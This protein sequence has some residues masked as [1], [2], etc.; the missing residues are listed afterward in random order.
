[1]SKIKDQRPSVSKDVEQLE[2]S[3]VAGGEQLAFS[4]DPAVPLLKDGQSLDMVLFLWEYS[5]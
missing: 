1:M 5:I 4:Y 3:C 2:L